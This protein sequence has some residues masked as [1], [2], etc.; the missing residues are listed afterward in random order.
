MKMTRP[1]LLDLFCGAGGASAGYDQA[2]WEVVGVDFQPQPR[3][4]FEFIQGDALDYLD[5]ELTWVDAIHASPPCQA[6]SPASNAS[7][8]KGVDY[9][10]LVTPVRDRLRAHRLPYVIENVPLA[11]IRRDLLLCGTM[12]LGLRV[13]RHRI[14]E[15]SFH[16]P[17][18]PHHKHPKV[19]N[20][21]RD[22]DYTGRDLITVAGDSARVQDKRRALE[23]WWM[24]SDELN[25]AIPPAYTKYV[26]DRLR[27]HLDSVLH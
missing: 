7:K 26:G 20:R 16:V 21:G 15:T 18:L 9:V 4:P 11:P 27:L 3:Y 8:A 12:F 10:D 25:E 22:D 17:R 6:F 14:F 5:R 23:I 2:G 19:H 24:E 13:L 1:V